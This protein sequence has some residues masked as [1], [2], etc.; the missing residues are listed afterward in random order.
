MRYYMWTESNMTKSDAY[1]YATAVA[2]ITII[3]A[4]TTHNYFLGLQYLGMKLRI[5]HC[6]LIYRKS[7]KLSQKAF[8][9]VTIGQLVNLLS[10]DINRFERTIIHLHTIWFSPILISV[11][12]YLIYYYVGSTACCGVGTFVLYLP[13][14]GKIFIKVFQKSLHPLKSSISSKFGKNLIE[15]NYFN[16]K[17]YQIV[18]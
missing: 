8:S 17:G 11:V 10:N 2:G 13:L 15:L 7:L 3:A 1:F 4:F 5:A 14:Q 18:F 16:L 6:S 9:T 12:L